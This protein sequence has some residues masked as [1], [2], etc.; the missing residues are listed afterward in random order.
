MPPPRLRPAWLAMV[1]VLV[2]ACAG[3]T[4]PVRSTP[5]VPAEEIRPTPALPAPPAV[6]EAVPK[7]A[8]PE[9][10]QELPDG[11][12]HVVQP[13]QTLWRIARAYDV[14]LDTVVA[15]NGIE[16]PTRVEIGTPVFIPGVRMTL[17]VEPYPAPLPDP[18]RLRSPVRMSLAD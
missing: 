14:P 17:D 4:A 12:V 16:D 15:A 3:V 10:P 2:P 18:R 9:T 11:V 1:L 6:P 13:G 7:P 8:E 5:R